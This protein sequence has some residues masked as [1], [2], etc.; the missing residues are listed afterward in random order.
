[1]HSIMGVA[2]LEFYQGKGGGGEGGAVPQMLSTSFWLK[3]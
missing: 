3:F 2:W 1:L